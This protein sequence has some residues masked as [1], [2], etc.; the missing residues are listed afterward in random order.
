MPPTSSGHAYDE[1]VHFERSLVLEGV[2]VIKFWLQIS[3]EEQ[4]RRFNKR[5][6]DPMRA[7]KLTEE[8]WRNREH[9]DEYT[10]AVDD[11]FSNTDHALAPWTVI[12]GEQKR[13]A[14]VQ[15]V[16][17]VVAEWRGRLHH[18][19]IQIGR[20][21]IRMSID[22]HNR[23]AIVTGAASGFG[24]AVTHELLR[25]G[26]TVV[27]TDVDTDG[28]LRLTDEASS[29][30]LRTQRLDVGDATAWTALI[31]DAGPFD[32]A[33]L[34]AGVATHHIRPE[35]ALP[36]LGLDTER[37]RTVMSANIDGVVFGTQAVL[38]HMT[39]TGF[40][41]IIVTA[42]VAGLVPIAPDPVYGLTKHAVVGFVRSLR[43]A[44]SAC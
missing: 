19:S 1:I 42:S 22:L 36:V 24:K 8:D 14:R 26:A 2:E 37:Y 38:E 13:W 7:W 28:S 29:D 21:R 12:S 25:S 34:N 15:I 11:M 17:N 33:I 4:L 43:R 16:E 32:L 41:D 10:A 20:R 35:G 40:G 39:A 27:A 44:R 18:L 31:A 30:A 5:K 23:R 3:P 9:A 6:K